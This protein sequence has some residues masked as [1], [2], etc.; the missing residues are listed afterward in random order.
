MLS[1]LLLL[2]CAPSAS[3]QEEVRSQLEEKYGITITNTDPPGVNT[4]YHFDYTNSN[5][6]FCEGSSY[7][8]DGYESIDP[9]SV[10][11]I[12]S[13]GRPLPEEPR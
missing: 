13:N 8:S 2:G 12:D 9:S 11:C 5:G 7:E 10:H 1:I 3:E 6:D 4:S